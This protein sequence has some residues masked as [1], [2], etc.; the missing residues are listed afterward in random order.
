MN[1]HKVNQDHSGAWVIQTWLS[2]VISVS[3]TAIGIIYL[4][5]D[6]WIK[7]YMGMGLLFSIGSTVSLTKTQ[8]DIYEGSK[9]TSRIEEAK[10]EKILSEHNGL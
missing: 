9:L 8:R 1:R 2:F 6:I 7:G 4:P 10:V 5:V 3:A